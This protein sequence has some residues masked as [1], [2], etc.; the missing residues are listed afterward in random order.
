MATIDELSPAYVRD[1][2]INL[3]LD[4]GARPRA[5]SSVLVSVSYAR[6]LPEGVALPLVLEVQG[7]S[8]RSYVRRDYTRAAPGSVIFTPQEGGPFVV[9]LREV[10]HNRWWGSLNLTVEGELIEPP[11]PV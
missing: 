8:H 2:R 10:G 7:P 5:N 4:V 11:K 3:T 1:K 6:T 9:T